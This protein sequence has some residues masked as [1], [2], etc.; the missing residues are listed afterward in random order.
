MFVD[1]DAILM[2]RIAL[3]DMGAM[4][5]LY[6]RFGLRVLNYLIG[7]LGDVGL[8]EE[9]LQ[10]VMLTVWKNAI[11]FRGESRVQTWLLAIARNRAINAR[12]RRRFDTVSLDE[13]IAMPNEPLH[14]LIDARIDG[15]E[16]RAALRRLPNDQRETLELVF[17]HQLSGPEAAAV[18][19]IAPGTV[20]SRLHRA[21][22]T[23]RVLLRKEA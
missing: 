13:A 18:L 5:A 19:G 20:K 1:P 23:L 7:Q 3:G 16:L 11:G 6:E 12:D 2:R 14:D 10:D 9:V 8:A 21:L 17:Y 4:D 22:T 15:D